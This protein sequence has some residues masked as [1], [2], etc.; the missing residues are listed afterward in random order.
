[1]QNRNFSFS[2]DLEYETS[3]DAEYLWNF[4]FPHCFPCTLTHILR[5]VTSTALS[6]SQGLLVY[7][8]NAHLLLYDGQMEK[9]NEVCW[10]SREEKEM[11]D[12]FS[13]SCLL[14][15][16]ININ[17]RRIY[18]KNHCFVLYLKRIFLIKILRWKIQ[19]DSITYGSQSVTF[20][21]AFM[22]LCNHALCWEWVALNAF[23]KCSQLQT[24][25]F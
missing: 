23:L 20:T 7:C 13:E 14:F 6:T 19:S 15:L 25:N 10:D 11:V 3:L 1:M 2:S 5:S 24:M 8:F 9:A 18:K 21:Q 17:V 12:H 16:Y 4:F 22:F